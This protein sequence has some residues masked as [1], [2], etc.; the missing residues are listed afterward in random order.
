[1][2][3]S[4]RN[5]LNIEGIIPS[6]SGLWLD[7]YLLTPEKANVDVKRKLV[8]CVAKINVSD[9]LYAEFY[10]RWEKTL[11]VKKITPRKATVK[12]RMVIGLG[13][14]SVL[15]TSVALHRTYG[16]PY[17]PGSALKGLSAAYAHQ[18]LKDPKWKKGG[19][20]HQVLFGDTTTAGYITFYDALYIPGSQKEDK[21]LHADV[22]TV[23]HPKYYQGGQAAP[24]DW[25]SPTPIPFLS[26]TGSYLIALS[27][28]PGADAWVD[29]AYEILGNALTEM[30]IGAKTSSGYGRMKLEPPP[31]PPDAEDIR[32]VDEF[33]QRLE[34]IPAP[35]VA[36]Q[37]FNYIEQWKVL[38]VNVA[39]KKRAA[40]G[41]LN[42][43]KTA[44]QEK[45][46]A[47]KAWYKALVAYL[48]SEI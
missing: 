29:V 15:E 26:A 20:A 41:I 28:S 30:G 27:T 34:K 37:I 35:K 5:K 38:E 33:L 8:K 44:N 32:V 25:D 9:S 1:M 47:E 45:A 40:Q 13:A 17:I 43:V 19:E 12:G 46:S 23:H 18:R 21:P 48:S 10:K 14:E 7:K 22:I 24:A 42:R 6:H 16:V 31:P 39:Q 11:Q 3:L 4:R 36:G 2:T